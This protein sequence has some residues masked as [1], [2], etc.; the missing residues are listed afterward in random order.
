MPALGYYRIR[1]WLPADQACK[2]HFLVVVAVIRGCLPCRRIYRE[3]V[4]LPS[5][6]V[7]ASVV[8]EFTGISVATESGF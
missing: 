8:Q 7:V 2:W 4:Q 1:E 5:C 6:K 3:F